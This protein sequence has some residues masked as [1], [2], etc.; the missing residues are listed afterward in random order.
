[1]DQSNNGKVL[2]DK[3]QQLTK[4]Y[5]SHVISKDEFESRK[6]EIMSSYSITLKESTKDIS[7]E[8]K[9]SNKLFFIIPLF[10]VLIS[11]VYLLYNMASTISLMPLFESLGRSNIPL[12]AVFFHRAHD[13]NKSMSTCN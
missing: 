2:D 6:K 10:L 4:L 7:P 11:A 5:M 3:I 13:C 12:I 1:M 9:Y 8:R